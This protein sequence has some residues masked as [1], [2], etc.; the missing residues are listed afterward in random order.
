MSRIVAE[1]YVACRPQEADVLLELAVRAIAAGGTMEMRVPSETLGIKNAI[2]LEEDV[3]FRVTH[4]RDAAGLNDVLA[5]DWEPIGTFP[6]PPFHG[7]LTVDLDED[8]RGSILSLEGE[9]EPPGSLLGKAFD[10]AVGFWIARATIHDL[11]RRIAHMIETMQ[12][13]SK[14]IKTL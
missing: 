7:V 4:S 10:E 14:N 2:A 3:R 9:Y 12:K 8:R 11:L 13:R 5:I 6:A 1:E